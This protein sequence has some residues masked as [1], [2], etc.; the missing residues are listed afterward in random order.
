[1]KKIIPFVPFFMVI[2]I[3]RMPAQVPELKIDLKGNLHEP[4]MLEQGFPLVLNVTLYSTQEISADRHIQALPDRLRQ[5]PN[6]L[7]SIDNTY[8]KG[9]TQKYDKPWYEE[10]VFMEINRDREDPLLPGPV[11]LNPLPEP[12]LLVK[13]DASLFA[14]FGIDPER[15]L[16][17]PVGK[18]VLKAGIPFGGDTIW[19]E[20]LNV[21]VGPVVTDL[22]DPKRLESVARYYLRRDQCV[23][24]LE[25]GRRL[26]EIGPENVSWLILMADILDCQDETQQA[27]DLYRQA[28]ELVR[29]EPDKASCPPVYLVRKIEALQNR[30]MDRN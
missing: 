4:V 24:A 29:N 13:L 8:R 3:F 17:W 16:D 28:L 18:L 20:K 6:V 11:I 23:V 5:D 10:I 15:T 12:E 25:F 7:D 1:M 2:G 19:S 21:L 9:F 14:D 26:L 22:E 30:L 27:L